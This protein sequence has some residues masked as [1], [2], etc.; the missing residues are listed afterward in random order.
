[1]PEAGL[2]KITR[3]L[4]TGICRHD[5]CGA[6]GNVITL[7]Q[8][9]VSLY[10]GETERAQAPGSCHPN[11]VLPAFITCWTAQHVTGRASWRVTGLI[12]LVWQLPD[13]LSGSSPPSLSRSNIPGSRG[14]I[15]SMIYS[16]ENGERWGN[17]LEAGLQS[18]LGL[19]LRQLDAC[20][21]DK[22]VVC[23]GNGTVV[24]ELV[25]WSQ[26]PIGC[27]PAQPTQ[28]LHCGGQQAQQRLPSRPIDLSS[29]HRVKAEGMRERLERQ[30]LFLWQPAGACL[31]LFPASS[32]CFSFSQ[33]AAL[34]RSEE[35][36]TNP[37]GKRCSDIRI[38]KGGLWAQACTQHLEGVAGE[39]FPKINQ[40]THPSKSAA[41][42]N[43]QSVS[44]ALLRYGTEKEVDSPIDHN[45]SPTKRAG[46]PAWLVLRTPL[47]RDS[48]TDR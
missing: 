9:G 7:E 22:T 33:G 34:C 11:A 6:H 45:I 35:S 2:V 1:M 36:T 43:S 13:A 38:E 46:S 16:F 5:L 30:P 8:G 48:Q 4:A 28:I 25:T 12:N 47:R 23:G 44:A 27:P 26:R 10:G 41:R 14:P 21:S 29:A 18:F 37:S 32:D 15:T 31:G 17:A 39:S 3:R 24:Q 40:K 42:L 19:L 20:Q